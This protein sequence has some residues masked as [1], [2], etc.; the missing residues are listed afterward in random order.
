MNPLGFFS[1]LLDIENGT[2]VIH[3]FGRKMKRLI[4]G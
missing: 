2:W 1:S 3:Q 4:T